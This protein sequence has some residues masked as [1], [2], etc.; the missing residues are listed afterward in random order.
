MMDDPVRELLRQAAE[1]RKIP[2]AQLSRRIG[3]NHAYL[4]QYLERGVPRKLPEEVRAA[5]AREL[6]LD[7][8]QLGAPP[9]VVSG[10]GSSP[11]TFVVPELDVRSGMGG[12][13]VPA[14]LWTRGDHDSVSA[15]GSVKAQWRV[16]ATF[17]RNELRARPEQLHIVEVVGD[18]MLG[19]LNPGDRVFI[20]V[21]HTTPSP[22]G[23]YALWDGFGVVVK[24]VELIPNSEPIQI[25]II[26][27]NP[28][29]RSYTLALDRV[30]II[31]RVC[32]RLTLL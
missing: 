15:E 8:V 2:L 31:G 32:A 11:A 28:K 24:R 4:Q 27:D 12:G 7:P 18:S 16:P 14:E 20:D 25:E 10:T 22:P 30:R 17:V 26:S 13:G 9:G 23:I 29:H 19:S 1:Q 5:L 6:S 21:S 3:R